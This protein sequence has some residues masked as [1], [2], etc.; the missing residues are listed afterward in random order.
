V[1]S[2]P[3][4]LTAETPQFNT[5]LVIDSTNT[6]AS[7]RYCF[8]SEGSQCVA[9]CIVGDTSPCGPQHLDDPEYYKQIVFLSS[10]Y[11][12]DQKA[13]FYQDF[14]YASLSRMSKFE[15]EK[16]PADG[17]YRVRRS[18]I[19]NPEEKIGVT[20]TNDEY[21][22]DYSKVYSVKNRPRLV[23]IG[24]WLPGGPIGSSSERFGMKA[25][26][27][28]LPVRAI[29]GTSPAFNTEKVYEEVS[30][31]TQEQEGRLRPWSAVLIIQDRGSELRSLAKLLIERP[32]NLVAQSAVDTV[33]Y[34]G[35]HEVGHSAFN[36]GDQYYSQFLL[37]VNFRWLDSLSPVL[38]ILD[39]QG[40]ASTAI[41]N[42]AGGFD[43]KLTDILISIFDDLDVTRYPSRVSTPSY[44]PTEFTYEGGFQFGVGVFH[45]KGLNIMNMMFGKSGE[46]DYMGE[47]HTTT[48]SKLID[49]E[50]L[51]SS[52]QPGNRDVFGRAFVRASR[53]N[54]RIRNAG[55]YNDTLVSGT[56]TRILLSDADKHHRYHPTRKYE[57]QVGWYESEIRTCYNK[58][59][60]PYA[61]SQNV[62]KTASKDVLPVKRKVKLS[63]QHINGLSPSLVNLFCNHFQGTSSPA[64][65][66]N[67]CLDWDTST[68]PLSD[69]FELMM[70]YQE[71]EVPTERMGTT[72]YWR[73][74]TD[75]GKW[76]SGWTG[77]STFKRTF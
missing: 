63:V 30:R 28:P 77:W 26:N 70:P 57:V 38:K 17:I 61:C 75:N 41:E 29:E 12:E 2:V 21:L 60:L 50:A 40:S 36:F 69:Y 52:F 34:L 13:L 51:G 33:N 25:L 62:W 3:L 64:G 74:R 37:Y 72:Y 68:L 32:F 16:E 22:V 42:W 67:K 4:M 45:E 35:Y 39:T 46:E 56:K 8:K 54:D 14:L 65:V 44:T 66:P 53:P 23:Y 55:P 6:S 19:L 48:Q 11:T 58:R 31:L 5:D 59:G 18:Q 71:V 24:W 15:I 7:T 47:D 76:Q 10:G 9:W 1:T 73:F 27:T 20:Y 43:F 49:N